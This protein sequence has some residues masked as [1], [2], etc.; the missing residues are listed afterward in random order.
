MQGLAVSQ[1]RVCDAN[2]AAAQRIVPKARVFDT[3]DTPGT[4]VFY[5]LGTCPERDKSLLP[6]LT[7]RRLG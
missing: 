3:T 7:G 5:G 1:D 2:R 4:P 6:V